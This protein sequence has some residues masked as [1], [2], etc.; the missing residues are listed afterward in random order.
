[1]QFYF[2]FKLSTQITDNTATL[3]SDMPEPK[4][5][6][7]QFVAGREGTTMRLAVVGDSLK[8]WYNGTLPANSTIYITGSYFTR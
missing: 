7:C 4:V 1:M 2:I 3:F 8:N 5:S 6:N